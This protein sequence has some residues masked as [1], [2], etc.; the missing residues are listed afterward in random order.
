[1]TRIIS[2]EAKCA[3]RDQQG[4]CAYLGVYIN[5][6]GVCACYEEDDPVNIKP[7]PIDEIPDWDPPTEEEWKAYQKVMKLRDD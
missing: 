5:E 3:F 2:C 1:M 7:V 6:G 4:H